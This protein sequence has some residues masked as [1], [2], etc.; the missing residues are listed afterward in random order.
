LL[1]AGK[2]VVDVVCGGGRVADRMRGY[3]DARFDGQHDEWIAVRFERRRTVGGHNYG[4]YFE[5]RSGA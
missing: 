1:R 2:S 4:E 3:S 5:F